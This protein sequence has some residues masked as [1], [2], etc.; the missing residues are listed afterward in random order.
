MFDLVR[1]AVEDL[2]GAARIDAAGEREQ[3]RAE[4]VDLFGQAV[5]DAQLHAR[6]DLDGGQQVEA[7]VKC[8]GT[9][10]GEFV[11]HLAVDGRPEDQPSFSSAS[12]AG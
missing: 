12:T 7:A 10:F 2:G 6:A 1:C 4:S 3:P 9:G 11:D 5:A 8:L